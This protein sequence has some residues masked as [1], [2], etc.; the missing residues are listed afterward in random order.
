[1]RLALWT[2]LLC[3]AEIIDA[4]R[5]FLAAL[6]PLRGDGRVVE[7]ASLCFELDWVIARTLVRVGNEHGSVVVFLSGLTVLDRP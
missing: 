1:M 6:K 7:D 4:D 3:V 5:T 2:P